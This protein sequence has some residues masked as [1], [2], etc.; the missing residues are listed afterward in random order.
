MNYLRTEHFRGDRLPWQQVIDH[1]YMFP[2]EQFY[3]LVD[4]AMNEHFLTELRE[5]W[6]AQAWRSMYAELPEGS[7]P[8]VSP[9][10]LAIA[11]DD[12]GNKIFSR[13]LRYQRNHPE[14]LMFLWSESS[15]G[16]LAVHLGRHAAITTSEGKRALL[17]LH[18]PNI[19]P[20]ALA[21]QTDE[22]RA[23]FFSRISEAWFSDLDK[24]WWRDRR[25]HPIEPHLFDPPAWNMDRHARFLALTQPRKLLLRLEE[26][27]AEE[28][29]GERVMWLKKIAG[30]TAQADRLGIASPDE[31]YVFCVASIYAG[32]HFYEAREVASALK[33]IGT[34][35]DCFAD[36]MQ[37]IPFEVWDRIGQ[38]NHTE[39]RQ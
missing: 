1:D 29:T 31:L 36:A 17:R 20:A 25:T 19:W 37:A 14:S 32:E 22:E 2:R 16:D 5:R 11:I 26:D 34:R 3:G 39:A 33:E 35:Y 24:T 10:L 38:I 8:E 21:V 12:L 4:G 7:H 18:D 27:H 23:Q 30:W 9:L 28:I 6:P 15:I 13:L